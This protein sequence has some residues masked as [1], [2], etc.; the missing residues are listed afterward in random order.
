MITYKASFITLFHLLI[1]LS[2]A[3]H[4]AKADSHPRMLITDYYAHLPSRYVTY[5][6]DIGTLDTVVD[7]KNGYLAKHEASH[8]DI[9]WFELALF[10]E[11]NG[12]AVV[13]VSNMKSDCACSTYESF[14][15]KYDGE[16]WQDVSKVVLPKIPLVSFFNS[17][18]QRQ[19]LALLEAKPSA[20]DYHYKL[21]QHGIVIELSLEICDVAAESIFNEAEQKI[22][23]PVLDNENQPFSKTL[24]L[25][26]NR[27]T[28]RFE[29]K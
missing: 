13:I 27:E 9:I 14:F 17:P 11:K 10:R 2:T 26:W 1:F 24:H 15:L 6:G 29:L 19:V 12:E 22:L 3:C 21:P 25:Q 4:A 8:P 16:E 23:W 20:I 5:T 18:P 7:T 28:D